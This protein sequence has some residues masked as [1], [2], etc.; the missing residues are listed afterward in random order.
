MKTVKARFEELDAEQAPAAAPTPARPEKRK[1]A[2]GGELA[3]LGTA[4]PPC[5]T[6][7]EDPAREHA[8]LSKAALAPFPKRVYV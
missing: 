1:R 7:G 8:R 5:G 6:R 2:R 3:A 4:E